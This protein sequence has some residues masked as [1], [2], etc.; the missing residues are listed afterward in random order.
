MSTT[1][2]RGGD[3]SDG[4]GGGPLSVRI[5]GRLR[6][7]I[8]GGRW[9]P[10]QKL[11]SMQALATEFGASVFPVAQ[12][13][14]RLQREGLVEARHGSGT[15]VQASLGDRRKVIRVMLAL[16]NVAELLAEFRREH[17]G[18]AVV[19]EPYIASAH[20]RSRVLGGASAPDLV[21]FDSQEFGYLASRGRLTA[22]GHTATD[23]AEPQRL[24]PCPGLLHFR[25]ERLG[26]PVTVTPFVLLAR[27]SVFRDSGEPLPPA[28]WTG[29]DML[30][31][32]RR[33]TRDQ[34]GDGVLDQFGYL[35]TL[36]SFTWYVIYRALGGGMSSWSAFA[37]DA[38][39][40]AA[41]EVWEA[42]FRHHICPPQI[43]GSAGTYGEVLMAAAG[44]RRVGMLLA[45]VRALLDC[46]ERYGD[47]FVPL[48]SPRTPDGRR[49]SIIGC[50][51]V[52]IPPRAVCRDGALAVAQFLRTKSVQARVCSYA[53]K[54]PVCVDLWE[55]ALDGQT[56][57]AR[58]LLNE[59][60]GAETLTVTENEPESAAAQTLLEGLMRG[61]ILPDEFERAIENGPPPS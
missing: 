44:T 57:L 2:V 8:E 52:G 23:E 35:T 31:I 34:D 55:G 24:L 39:R 58:T 15:Y 56:D 13:V 14:H 9:G 20:E 4:G 29:R 54:L 27:R 49:A 32:A 16:P 1:R 61:V 43:A 7:C 53:S 33:L 22:I 36:R 40:A 3:G 47:D 11:P 25:G 42:V 6:E 28:D 17:P 5:S 21:S 30:A 38:S 19:S 10:G 41:L 45:D 18:Y 46:R 12:A 51:G 37:T 60:A 59:A 50:E 26:L 48:P